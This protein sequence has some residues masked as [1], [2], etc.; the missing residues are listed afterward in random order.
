MRAFKCDACGGF[1]ERPYRPNLMVSLQMG[2]DTD[3]YDICPKCQEQLEELFH[4]PDGY[5]SAKNKE[6][7]KYGD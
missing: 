4:V 3:T 2:E 6:W 1:F 5:R 7:I